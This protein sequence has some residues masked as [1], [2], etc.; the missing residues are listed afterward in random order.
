[1]QF[2]FFRVAQVDLFLLCTRLRKIYLFGAAPVLGLLLG[3]EC[4]LFPAA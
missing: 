1:M 4:Y 3:G 2:N